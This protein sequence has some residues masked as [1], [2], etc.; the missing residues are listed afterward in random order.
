MDRFYQQRD[1]NAF[2]IYFSSVEMTMEVHASQIRYQR[3]SFHPAWLK[4]SQKV[5]TA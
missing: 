1:G 3:Q 5:V 2:Y 4:Y